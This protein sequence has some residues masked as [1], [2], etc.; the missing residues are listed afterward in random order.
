[1]TLVII[2]GPEKAGKTTLIA[3]L[4][5][6]L[7]RTGREAESIHWGRMDSDDRIYSPY[8][9]NHVITN[10]IWV[11]DR[12]WPSEHVYGVLLD[13][14]RRMRDNPWIG[15]WLHGRAAQTNGVRIILT[16][17]NPEEMAK[18]RDDSDH[19]VAPAQEQELYR[20][21]GEAFKWHVL[22]NQHTKTNLNE[23]VQKI[24]ALILANKQV[25]TL[26]ASRWCGPAGSKVGFF[27]ARLAEMPIPGGWLPFTLEQ[28]SL[29][30]Q[31]TLGIS[32]F[33]CQWLDEDALYEP[34]GSFSKFE[35]LVLCGTMSEKVF[36][37]HTMK[38]DRPKKIIT[39]SDAEMAKY[40]SEAVSVAVRDILS[41]Q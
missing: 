6:H 15:E 8:V 38:G 28:Q 31:H 7:R 25:A 29:W 32:A 37:D 30:V 22:S 24:D 13:R 2:D 17:P 41:S 27:S 5:S 26:S 20:W 21:Y 19:I 18:L 16:G 12:G 33:D 9:F 34:P 3:E 4:V 14:P 10:K 23:Q 1:M 40:H 35:L 11:W 39:L 36:K